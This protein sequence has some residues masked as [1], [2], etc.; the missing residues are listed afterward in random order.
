VEAQVNIC[1]H[2]TASEC[3]G[4][5]ETGRFLVFSSYGQLLPSDTDT[6]KDV[7][8]YDAAT[9]A[10]ARV[11]IGEEGADLNG[12]RDDI[13]PL[14]GGS[15]T[16]F[17]DASIAA[18]N[19][20]FPVAGLHELGSRA[21]SEDGSRIVFTTAEPLSP[22]ASNGLPDIYEWHKEPAWSEGR[23]SLISSGSALTPDAYPVI[24]PSGRDV[25]FRTS[26]GL[27]G[28]D[29]DGEN[30][31]YDARLGG[32]FPAPP[33]EPQEC[34]DE[35][36]RGPLTN[37]A[38]LLVPGSVAQVSGENL[39]A[40]AV[41]VVKAKA[42]AKTKKKRKARKKNVHKRARDKQPSGRKRS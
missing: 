18:P 17:A 6:A 33:A 15:I 38:P 27:V 32:G 37:P 30:D 1:G 11:S 22:R 19:A 20:S 2:L 31:I 25:F 40:P 29:T 7:Y 26:Q 36:C 23:V 42:K 8:R 35:A 28:G 39:P 13:E 14:S 34:S 24:T 10:L 16:T 4:E 9:G 12:N 5:D 21:V 41:E 3:L